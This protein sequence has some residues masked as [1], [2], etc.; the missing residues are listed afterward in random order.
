MPPRSIV[1]SLVL[2]L[3]TVSGSLVV[4]FAPL[5]LPQFVVKYGG[6]TLWALMVYWIVSALLP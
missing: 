3:A 4:R 5:G 2:M 1:L 6:S